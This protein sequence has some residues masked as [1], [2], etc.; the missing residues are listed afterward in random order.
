MDLSKT[1]VVFYYIQGSLGYGTEVPYKL[2]SEH[3]DL[4]LFIKHLSPP[5]YLTSNIHI[6]YTYMCIQL[7]LSLSLY[8]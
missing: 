3:Y 1:I 2:K 5:L 7:S 4:L 6:N 8:I